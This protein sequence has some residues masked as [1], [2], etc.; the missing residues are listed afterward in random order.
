MENNLVD[1]RCSAIFCLYEEGNFTELFHSCWES[2]SKKDGI[3]YDLQGSDGRGL[4]HFTFLQLI[5]FDS[6]EKWDIDIINRHVKILRKILPAQFR[7]YFNELRKVSAG[8]IL[9]GTSDVNI[10]FLRNRYRIECFHQKLKINEPYHNDILHST[11]YRGV[12]MDTSFPERIYGNFGYVV[13]RNFHMG[14]CDLLMKN[15]E[16][17]ATI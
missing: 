1:K 14:Y 12:D 8:Y 13:I 4:L 5:G 17:T 2:L 15:Y 10:N 9:C 16:I 7:I 11:V 3:I 6:F